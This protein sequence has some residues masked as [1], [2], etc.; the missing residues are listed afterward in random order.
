MTATALIAGSPLAEARRARFHGCLLGGAVGDALGAPVEFLKRAEILRAFGSGGIRDMAP[1]YGRIG[2]ITDDTQMAAFT[3]EGLLRAHA[4]PTNGRSAHPPSV[5]AR[6]YLRWLYTQGESHPLQQ[7]ALD[8]WL[9]R[10]ADLHAWRAPG[11]TCLDALRA[12][13]DIGQPAC[14][15]SKGCGGIMRVAPV[16]MFF[17]AKAGDAADTAAPDRLRACFDLGCEAAGLTHG[18]V[19]G[20]L[21][22]GAYAALIFCA[23]TDRDLDAAIDA[24]LALLETRA[25]HEETATALR[26]ARESADR[27][28]A[29][30]DALARLGGGWVAEEAL[31]IGVYCALSTQRFEEGVVLAVNHSG[32]SDSTGLLTGHLLGAV[33]GLSAIPER[34]LAPLE[35]RDVLE[36]LA[37]DLLVSGRPAS[38]Q[39]ERC[40]RHARLSRTPP[41]RLDRIEA[42]ARGEMAV[43]RRPASGQPAYSKTSVRMS[44]TIAPATAI[45]TRSVPQT[46][47]SCP[48]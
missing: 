8:G 19:T 29:S 6:A 13:R 35:L 44:A 21:S 20:Q 39:D 16:G 40:A 18:H 12:L 42:A 33:Q 28:P 3:A 34:W 38:L 9:I 10:Q 46:I 15:H 30:P 4:R 26:R 43:L 14:N 41:R 5:L 22:A 48:G 7:G 45:R 2:A 11:N 31:A 17:A 1:A 25:G 37:D 47:H 27:E 24:V 23:L 32:D 36:Q